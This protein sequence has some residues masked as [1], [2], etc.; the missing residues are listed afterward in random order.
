M[1]YPRLCGPDWLS[2][3]QIIIEYKHLK[4][5]NSELYNHGPTT[6]NTNSNDGAGS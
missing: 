5:S 2:Y 4:T 1:S 6:N 3:L